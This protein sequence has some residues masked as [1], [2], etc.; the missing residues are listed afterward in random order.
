MTKLPVCCKAF[1]P[2][3]TEGE[4]DEI[5][6]KTLL[7]DFEVTFKFQKGMPRRR[8]LELLQWYCVKEQRKILLESSQSKLQSLEVASRKQAFADSCRQEVKD[9]MTSP[10]AEQL[11]LD[12]VAKPELSAEWLDKR[13][14]TLYTEVVE[15]ASKE[16][17]AEEKLLTDKKGKLEEVNKAMETIN[18]VDVVTEFV[19]KRI[20]LARSSDDGEPPPMEEDDG[21]GE[22]RQKKKLSEALRMGVPKNE[23]G[24]SAP[25]DKR[26][27]SRP[28]LGAKDYRKQR[29]ASWSAK[30]SYPERSK[31]G[32][33]GEWKPG[34]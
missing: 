7:Q 13:I 28:V 22:A 1:K 23:A 17:R 11:G 33:Y 32:W 9:S 2:S 31:G 26:Q 5:W 4:L 24:G 27:T 3:T 12:C 20:L 25:R 18:P 8:A 10:A 30:A 29:Q 34:R 21:D 6:S 14:T 19:D 16:H 15:S